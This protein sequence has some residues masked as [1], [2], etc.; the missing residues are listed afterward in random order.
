MHVWMP[1]F[2]CVGMAGYVCYTHYFDSLSV[3]F[4]AATPAGVGQPTAPGRRLNPFQNPIPTPH[5]SQTTVRNCFP[6]ALATVI[7]AFSQTTR[8]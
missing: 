8:H 7:A 6:F 4:M 2:V 5:D 3:I 1:M